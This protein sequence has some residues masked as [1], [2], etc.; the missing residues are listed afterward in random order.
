M[1][2][3]M[4]IVS[5]WVK[6]RVQHLILHVTDRC[7]LRCE[8]CFVDLTQK[9]TLTPETTAAIADDLDN[10]LW[11]DIGGGEPFLLDN[12]PELIAPFECEVLGIPTNG[13]FP[14]KTAALAVEILN[15][16]MARDV[17]IGVSVEGLG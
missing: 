8:H 16:A 12:L 9:N 6:P 10:I 11:L 2:V 15:M 5:Y 13:H 4:H 1:S 17:V 3:P 7:N 14:E